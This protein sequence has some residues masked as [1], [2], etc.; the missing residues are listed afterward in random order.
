MTEQ[1]LLCCTVGMLAFANGANDNFKGVAT[2][3]GSGCTDY[4]RALLWATVATGVGSLLAILLGGAL[5]TRFT[6]KGLVANDLVQTVSF[7]TTVGAS[8]GVTVLLACRL[9]FPISTTHAL[10]GGMLGAA[11]GREAEIHWAALAW[12]VIGPLLVSPVMAAAGAGLV[13]SIARWSSAR[14]GVRQTL[15]VC[16]TDRSSLLVGN[17]AATTAALQLP[18]AL[19]IGDEFTCAPAPGVARIA[20]SPPDL[21]ETAHW[22]SAG[23]VCLARG[24]NDT[25]KLAALFLVATSATGIP[26]IALVSLLIALGGWLAARRVAETMSHRITTIGPE[27][28]LVANLMAG[29]LVT[30]ATIYGLPV[31]TT[32]VCCGAIFGIGLVTGKANPMVIWNLILAWVVTLPIAA[33]LAFMLSHLIPLLD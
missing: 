3:F 32:H 8:A 9:G 10:V 15:C 12:T 28:G 21:L 17:V 33:V 31:S 14:V 13:F 29:L 7:A 24:L 2:L 19:Q 4:R 1:L 20:I 23:W 30:F 26:S 5:L 6:G 18:L 27:D 16:I 25:P 11:L 22:W